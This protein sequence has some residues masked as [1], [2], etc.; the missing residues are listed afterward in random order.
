MGKIIKTGF[1]YLLLAFTW[2]AGPKVPDAKA[3]RART[4]NASCE[5]Y[6]SRFL[7]RTIKYCSQRS[8]PDI[9]PQ[10]GEPVVYFFHGLGGSSQSFIDNGYSEALRILA[11]KEDFPPFTMISFDTA[12]MS[13]FSD[14]GGIESGSAAYESWFI[15]EFMPLME[16]KFQLCRERRCRGTAGLSMGG[17]GAL[18]IAL[19]FSNMFSFAAVNSAALVP[20][21]VWDSEL[22]WADYFRRHPVGNLRGQLL[23]REARNIFSTREQFNWNNPTWLVSHF[24]DDL[25]LP[26]IY[27]D[28]GGQDY[29]GFQ[30]GFFLLKR[31]L[32]KR[33]A[34]FVSDFNPD[35]THDQFWERRWWLLRY[36]RDRLEEQN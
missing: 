20:L 15:K 4:Q 1:I 9:N 34:S 13:F 36:I 19:R 27:M 28:V 17:F 30:E 6:L 35:G 31:E 11:S 18:K 21:N 26:H 22:L 29:F 24:G 33:N 10:V 8:R 7:K 5:S 23:L 2:G 3:S 16:N 32:E 25:Q 12:F 14:R